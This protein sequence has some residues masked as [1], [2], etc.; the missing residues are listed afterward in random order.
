MKTKN[1]TLKNLKKRITPWQ[2]WGKITNEEIQ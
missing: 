2:N 1:Y